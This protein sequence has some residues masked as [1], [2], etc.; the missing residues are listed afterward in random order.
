[1]STSIRFEQ[2]FAT[3]EDSAAATLKSATA[4]AGVARQLIKASQVGDLAKIE[5]LLDRLGETNATLRQE[6]GNTEASWHLSELEVQEYLAGDFEQ[7]LIEQAQDVG[8]VV[9]RQDDR[10]VAY[11]SLLRVLPAARA[12]EIDRK[13]LAILR[14][15]RLVA[16]LLANQQK[17]PSS[18]P[19]QFL[20]ILYNAYRLLTQGTVGE[21]VALSK[22]H[23]ALTM[24]PSARKEYPKPDFTR[25]LYSLDIS[26]ARM[27]RSGL[28]Y[29]LPASTGTKSTRGVL[30]FVSPEGETINYFGIRFVEVD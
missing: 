22:I 27:T 19:E 1:M 10:L 24:L 16:L 29:S 12:M 7:E 21:T 11:P 30:S 28:S 6:V 26:D 5:R 23:D 17:K 20:E 3:V 9:R 18:K 8:L 15:S 2:A 25:D 4:L 13:R 14:P